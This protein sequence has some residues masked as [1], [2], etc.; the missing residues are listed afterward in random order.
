MVTDTTVND[1]SFNM[2]RKEDDHPTAYE[3]DFPEEPW[4]KKQLKDAKDVNR[5]DLNV[6]VVLLVVN[7][8]EFDAALKALSPLSENENCVWHLPREIDH[9]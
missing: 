9:Y 2:Q 5:N 8:I 3:P 1:S 6:D 4:Y 7:E